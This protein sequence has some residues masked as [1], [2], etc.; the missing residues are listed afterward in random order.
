MAEC[1]PFIYDEEEEDSEGWAYMASC[2]EITE[3]FASYPSPTITPD[4]YFSVKILENSAKFRTFFDGFGFTPAARLEMTKAIMDIAEV[5]QE[6]CMSMEGSVPQ[7]IRD[8]S[9]SVTFIDADRRVPFP[10]NRP[11]YVTAFVNKVKMLL[12]R[13]WGFHQSHAFINF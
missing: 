4:P 8:E 6:A 11:V 9:N 2:Y 5:H 1:Y 3:D 10:H 13:W 12:P 7:T